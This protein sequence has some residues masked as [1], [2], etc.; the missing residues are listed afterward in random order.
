MDLLKVLFGSCWTW[1][2]L[3]I[4]KKKIKSFRRNFIIVV[5]KMSSKILVF[6]LFV[7][8][9][10]L[11]QGFFCVIALAVLKLTL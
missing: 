8:C 10:F 7:F 9:F 6:C 1:L 11:R 2:D 5:S 4:K 3:K